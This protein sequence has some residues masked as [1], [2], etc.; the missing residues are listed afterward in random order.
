[1][2]DNPTR[3]AGTRFLVGQRSSTKV[4]ASGNSARQ[5]DIVMY[6]TLVCSAI[7]AIMI[8]QHYYETRLALTGSAVL[9]LVGSIAFFAARGS[10]TSCTLLTVCNVGAV[11]LHI[12]VS[13]GVT[14][15]HF[16]VFV[17]LGLLLVYRD[18][19]PIVL[20]AVLF[21]IHHIAFDRLQAL[22]FAVF[23][24]ESP[25]LPRVLLHA[26]YVVIQTAIEIFLSRQLHLAAREAG[27]LSAIIAR[28]DLN[29]RVCL[30]VSDIPTIT[31][32]ALALKGAIGKMQGAL[33]EV[34]ESASQ[35]EQA[36]T[37]IAHGTADLSRRT[38]SQASSLQETA[39]SMK[40]F[41]STVKQNADN[42]Q[43][44]SQLADTA[45]AVAREGGAVVSQVV[46]T[47]G[48]IDESAKRIS[49]IT[50]VIDAIAFQT[51]ILALNA[52][53]EAARAG[54]QGR[55]FAVVASE[56]RNLAQRSATAA[57]E[58]KQ[59][60]EDSAGKV[61]D[62]T[63]L[64]DRA[65]ATMQ[66]VVESIRRVADIMGQITAASDEQAKGIEQV[67]RVIAQMDDAT[68]RDTVIVG[69][70]AGAS[71]SLH[72]TTQGL[73]QVVSVFELGSRSG[74]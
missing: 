23:C 46:K 60:I 21:A 74:N 38:E 48:S 11:A 6:L 73:R 67:N 40:Q 59:L 8:G 35:V 55:G 39:V 1:M 65:G 66:K 28:V 41:T 31:P 22:N 20:A 5:A 71:A 62:G 29:G 47:M 54:E 68:Q 69:E 25:N 72:E 10:Q 56:V 57:K 42:A 64:V 3:W 30:V 51:N 18:W 53:V 19:R 12:Q 37:E 32:P 44:A 58:I 14:E 34:S 45:S 7:G 50:G 13:H 17:L 43:Q 61:A 26:C 49:E 63:R 33:L 15:F 2:S 24:T 16:G 52:A 36:A 27:E 9:L 70:A 4:E